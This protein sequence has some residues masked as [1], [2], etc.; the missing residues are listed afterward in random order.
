MGLFVDKAAVRE[1]Q[2]FILRRLHYLLFGAFALADMVTALALLTAFPSGLSYPFAIAYF[3]Y[4]FQHL[5]VLALVVMGVAAVWWLMGNHAYW[6]DICRS[7]EHKRVLAVGWLWGA[8]IDLTTTLINR[9]F[10]LA[11]IGDGTSK[12]ATFT[13]GVVARTGLWVA[14]YPVCAYGLLR[15]LQPEKHIMPYRRR[16]NY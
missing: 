10:P 5:V 16:S 1:A 2:Q 7:H 12:L 6:A 14:L 11:N 4:E 3:M 9:S 8:A 13:V 15:L